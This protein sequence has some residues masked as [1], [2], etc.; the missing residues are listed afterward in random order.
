VSAPVQQVSS[1]SP[2][3]CSELPYIGELS[4]TLPPAANSAASTSARCGSCAG[5]LPTSKP[6]QVPRPMTGS[7]AP[8]EGMGRVCIARR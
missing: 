7:G 2:A 6:R 3:T 8:V 1:N 5:S 4:T